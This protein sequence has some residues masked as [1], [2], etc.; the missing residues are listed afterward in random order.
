MNW[1]NCYSMN[2]KLV[3]LSNN[4]WVPCGSP[5]VLYVVINNRFIY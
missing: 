5:T 4:E 2:Y 1:L 3:I